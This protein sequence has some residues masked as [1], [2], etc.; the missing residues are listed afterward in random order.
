PLPLL[1]ISP[2]D[3]HHQDHRKTAPVLRRGNHRHRRSES[4]LVLN[5]TL[6]YTAAND[7]DT[8]KPSYAHEINQGYREE[9]LKDGP[10]ILLLLNETSV[11]YPYLALDSSESKVDGSYVGSPRVGERGFRLNDRDTC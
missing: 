7:Q 4:P 2:H 9:C 1:R 10:S 11:V 3:R 6:S 5:P 8:R